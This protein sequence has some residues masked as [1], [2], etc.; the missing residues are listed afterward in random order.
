MSIDH[1]YYIIR[2]SYRIIGKNTKED[3]RF[4]KSS[5]PTDIYFEKYLFVTAPLI[6]E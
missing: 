3:I 1:K 6:G 5:F 4:Q 2:A